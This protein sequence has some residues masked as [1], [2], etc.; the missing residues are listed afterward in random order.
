MLT[1]IKVNS[2]PYTIIQDITTWGSGGNPARNL[3][4]LF[5]SVFD[6][7]GLKVSGPTYDPKTVTQLSY[8]LPDGR[9]MAIAEYTYNGETVTEDIE[10][11]VTYSVEKCLEDLTA[12]VL[13]CHCET[14][15]D[16]DKQALYELQVLIEAI[17]TLQT[18]GEYDDAYCV[19]GQAQAI[20]NSDICCETC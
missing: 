13:S 4:S 5:I 2:N 10:F 8:E 6:V 15:K 19:F 11:I 3:F 14:I 12:K 9:Y 20:C 18:A 17:G 16:E 1:I 7:N